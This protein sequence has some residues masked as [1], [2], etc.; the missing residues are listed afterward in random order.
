M[1][2]SILAHPVSD[3]FGDCNIYGSKLIAETYNSVATEAFR[4]WTS[5]TEKIEYKQLWQ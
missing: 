3:A 1:A 5:N 2:K 4:M